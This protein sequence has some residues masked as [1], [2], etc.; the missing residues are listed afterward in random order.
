MDTLDEITKELQNIEDHLIPKLKLDCWERALYYHLIRHT[1][2]IG[3]DRAQ[4]GLPSLAAS[5]GFSEDTVRERIR[6]LDKRGCIEI[7]ERSRKGHLLRVLLPTEIDG[8]VPKDCSGRVDTDINEINFYS[9]RKHVN[10]IIQREQG[11]CFYC[12]RSLTADA[13]VLDHAVPKLERGNDSFRNIV[14]CCHE[15]NAA[16]QGQSAE[17]FIRSRYRLNLLSEGEFVERIAALEK[18][19]AGQLVPE[20]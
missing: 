5:T 17:A 13:C 12:L 16:K 11:K 10:A 19:K 8:I 2:L 6:A 20:V 15:C 4:F 9:G 3:R 14:A 1:R 18:L 7:M